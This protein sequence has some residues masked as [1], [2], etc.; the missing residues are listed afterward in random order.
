MSNQSSN[1]STFSKA[2]LI[3][4]LTVAV[5]IETL[6]IISVD[7]GET[8]GN[9]GPMEIC[10][11]DSRAIG[12]QTQNDLLDVPLYDKTAMNSIRLFCNDSA[13]TNI[14]SKLGE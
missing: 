3:L 9:W 1:R 10:P 4:L 6:T 8:L 5:S 13:R 11:E 12:Y 7:N 2:I 14:T